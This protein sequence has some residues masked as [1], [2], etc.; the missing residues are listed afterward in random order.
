MNETTTTARPTSDRDNFVGSEDGKQMSDP[1][2]MPRIG[3]Y[4]DMRRFTGRSYQTIARWVCRKKL[5]PGIYVG[6]GMFN[7]SRIRELFDKNETFFLKRVQKNG[8]F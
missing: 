8:K 6:Q 3:T 5:R 4:A 7:M 1:I 2:A